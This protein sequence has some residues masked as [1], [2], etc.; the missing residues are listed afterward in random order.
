MSEEILYM[1][2][3]RPDGFDRH[4]VHFEGAVLGESPDSWFWQFGD[5]ATATVQN[6]THT[7]DRYGQYTVILTAW[8]G[9]T[10]KTLKQVLVI[11]GVLKAE[12]R[13]RAYSLVPGVYLERLG[14]SARYL[15]GVRDDGTPYAPHPIYPIPDGITEVKDI[16]CGG[17]HF[18][19]IL[20]DNSVVAWGM[21]LYG[22]CDVPTGLQA[23]QVAAGHYGVSVALKADGTVVTWGAVGDPPAGLSGVIQIAACG[24][25]AFALKSDGTVVAW[26]NRNLERQLN[27][28]V[29]LTDVV[30]ISAL[31]TRALALKSDGTVVAWGG[32]DYYYGVD[33]A[34]HPPAGLLAS[35]ISC[36]HA[37]AVAVTPSG[38][39]RIW[40]GD[41]AI[42][43]LPGITTTPE[44]IEAG[45]RAIYYLPAEPILYDPPPLPKFVVD[46]EIGT[47][48]LEVQF[49]DL[50]VGPVA[51]WFWQFGDGATATVQN[52]THT[53]EEC[54]RYT[55]T[56]TISDSNGLT[57]DTTGE[58][59]VYE[60]RLGRRRRAA[61]M[62][63]ERPAVL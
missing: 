25:A 6:P 34:L 46:P 12:R 5:G 63:M 54:G 27:V 38:E 36:G 59:I 9:D 14:R 53:Y 28:P 50:T 7:Y 33:G 15:V 52:P 18:L 10:P 4:T 21:N 61:W 19:A 58:V 1:A 47:P 49:T 56:L 41:P 42:G 26:G 16:V 31:T 44:S 43:G 23:V 40:Y 55:V 2:V 57:A 32:Y 29:G 22:E 24:G 13:A 37:E 3:S 11:G 35:K 51:S 45:Y 17:D 48:P 60:P 20:P 39:V 30:E 62:N 8:Y